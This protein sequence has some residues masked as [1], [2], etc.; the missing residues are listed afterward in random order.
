MKIRTQIAK[1]AY[2]WI[3]AVF[4]I[5]LSLPVQASE[6]TL[7]AAAIIDQSVVNSQGQEIGEIEDLVIRRNGSVKKAL[8]SDGGFLEMGDKV[9]SVN[10]KSLK[11]DGGKIILDL[12][13]KQLSDR[14]EFDY[15]ENGLFR[16]YHYRMHSYGMMSG[17]YGHRGPGMAP[18]HPMRRPDEGGRMPPGAE[19]QEN[20][21][22]DSYRAPY[23]RQYYQD[24]GSWPNPWGW[25]YYPARM[26]ASVVL[27]QAVINKEGR[28]VAT[29]E[30]L[31]I[32]AARKVEQLILSYGGFI[33]IG[34]KRVAVPYRSIGFTYRG[35]IYDITRRE[36]ENLPKFNEHK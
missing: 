7:S 29:V 34:D 6:N 19:A 27:G 15:R 33:D 30:D 17:P 22:D 12:S 21:P 4:C 2:I 8:I 10:Y 32:D 13:Q 24:R 28:V 16:A 36:L 23:F 9:V 3:T 35:I 26:L 18:G 20:P 5:L 25:S 14:S 1:T 31:L 11:F